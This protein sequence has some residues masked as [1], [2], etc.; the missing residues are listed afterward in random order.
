LPTGEVRRI[1]A[2]GESHVKR[3]GITR[4]GITQR[5][6]EAVKWRRAQACPFLEDGDQVTLRAWC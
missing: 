1:L 4:D 3:D 6:A 2:G 5:G